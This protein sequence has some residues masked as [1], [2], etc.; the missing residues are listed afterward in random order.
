MS[1]EAAL[2]AAL[3]FCTSGCSSQMQNTGLPKPASEITTE[4]IQDEKVK[5]ANKRWNDLAAQLRLINDGESQSLKKPSQY[6][7]FEDNSSAAL[8]ELSRSLA[9]EHL[10]TASAAGCARVESFELIGPAKS[11]QAGVWLP[12]DLNTARWYLMR[13][14]KKQTDGSADPVVNGALVSVPTSSAQTYPVVAYAH[15]GDRG[16][17]ALEI[18][19][20]FNSL[21]TNHIIVAPAYPGEPICKFGTTQSSKTSCDNSGRYFDAAGASAPYSTDAEDLLA[22]HNCLVGTPA[23]HPDIASQVSS[24]IKTQSRAGSQT[25]VPVSYIMGSSRGGMTALL[26]LAKNTALLVDNNPDAKF[27]NCAATNINPTTFAVSEFRVFL[28]AAVKGTAEALDSYAL[29]TAPQLNELLR[30]YREGRMSTTDAALMLQVRDATFNAQ[31][32]LAS[33]RNWQTGG[34]GSLLSLHGTLD[35]SIP[36]S[37]GLAGGKV[38]GWMNRIIQAQHQ[39]NPTLP[40]GVQ[41]T[42]LATIAQPPYS[43][44]G[45]KTLLGSATMHGDFAWFESRVGVSTALETAEGTAQPLDSS[46][47]F[48]NKKP[49]EAFADW[50]SNNSVGCAAAVP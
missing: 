31:L 6:F 49:L 29:P 45:G 4:D 30:D 41:L 9:R 19:A 13:Y 47:P 40:A 22:A 34:R 36:I 42:T 2:L 25:P 44:D 27:F 14:R 11:L 38:F 26:A 23:A 43:V 28:E 37:Q 7:S 16:L 3:I 12:A 39:A 32:T 17:S 46:S 33:L 21:Q 24:K 1:P 35:K 50:L 8:D 48:F 20:V 5:A 10:K 15:A 18:A